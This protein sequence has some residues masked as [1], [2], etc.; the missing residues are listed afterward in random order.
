[1]TTSE[2]I[3]LT[4]AAFNIIAGIIAVAV[5]YT[6]GIERTN[7]VETK[8]QGKIDLVTNDLKNTNDNLKSLDKR[9]TDHEDKIEKKL[10]GL[11]NDI[12]EVKTLLIEK[13]SK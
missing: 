3:A 8:L 12:G 7:N 4:V 9:V 1:M 2:I 5:T 11:R 6:K 10:D 13:L